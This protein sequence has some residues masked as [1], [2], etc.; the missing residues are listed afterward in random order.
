[1]RSPRTARSRSP[2]KGKTTPLNT[3]TL[4]ATCVRK[5]ASGWARISSRSGAS[6]RHRRTAGS[7]TVTSTAPTIAMLPKTWKA[8]KGV[9]G[10]A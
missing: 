9:I 10:Q 7:Q 3:G 5:L 2:R 4:T 1:M 6:V 8:N